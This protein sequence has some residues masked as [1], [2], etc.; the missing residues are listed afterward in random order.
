MASI[1]RKKKV[2]EEVTI[3][4][5]SKVTE[6]LE[7]P[8]PYRFTDWNAKDC[9]HRAKA[10]KSTL[11]SFNIKPEKT[12]KTIFLKNK[13]IRRRFIESHQHT[14][15]F[16]LDI[17]ERDRVIGIDKTNDNEIFFMRCACFFNSVIQVSILPLCAL[18]Q[19]NMD[20]QENPAT[21]KKM[22]V[23]T[24]DVLVL[25]N[26]PVLETP[27]QMEKRL[28]TEQKLKG[29]LDHPETFCLCGECKI[30]IV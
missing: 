4:I 27:L 16:E 5:L 9:I 18:F 2:L 25:L 23:C 19:V 14:I 17:F 24:I 6:L 12:W 20:Y 26:N 21:K 1:Q 7:P 11:N 30:E 10:I 29:D 8:V 22:W 3:N 15:S 13:R 28:A